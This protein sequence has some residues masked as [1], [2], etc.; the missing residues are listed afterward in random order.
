MYKSQEQDEVIKKNNNNNI[1]LQYYHFYCKHFV[2][3]KGE[4]KRKKM[5]QT[6]ILVP[7]NEPERHEN[8]WQ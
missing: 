7:F 2:A 5:S 3:I 4:K 6:G 8:E 1:N